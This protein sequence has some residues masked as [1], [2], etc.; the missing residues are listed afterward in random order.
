MGE[1]SKLADA[2][3]VRPRPEDRRSGFSLNLPHS[4]TKEYIANLSPTRIFSEFVT[5]VGGRGLCRNDLLLK[6][7]AR[8]KQLKIDISTS[9]LTSDVSTYCIRYRSLLY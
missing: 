5:S 1:N 2:A 6:V 8:L 7:E 9:A 3:R 4:C